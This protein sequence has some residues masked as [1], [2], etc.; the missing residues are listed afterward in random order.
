MHMYVIGMDGGGTKTEGVLVG[1][2][3]H[4]LARHTTGPSNPN[5]CGPETSVRVIAGLAQELAES[6]GVPLTACFLFA[7]IAGSLNH[8]EDMAARLEGLCG[9]RVAVDS[10][11]VNLLSAELADRDGACVI[12]GTGSACFLRMGGELTRIGGWGYLLDSAGSGYDIGRQALEAALRAYDGRGPETVLTAHLAERLGAPV[13]NTLSRLYGEG[14]PLIAS[15]APVVFEAAA[16]GDAIAGAILDRNAVA[17]AEMITTAWQW[18]RAGRGMTSSDEPSMP[19]ALD[20]GVFRRSDPLLRTAV[21]GHIPPDVP[22]ELF[23]AT[24]PVI[25]GAVSEGMRRDGWS[26]ADIRVA[27]PTFLH[28][29]ASARPIDPIS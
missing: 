28:D 11:M 7:G 21:L 13:Q 3:G 16:D 1:R 5:D 27:E 20:G 17:L 9:G 8:K 25:W 2:E 6:A 26:E 29:L 18:Y 10:D 4:V 24:H 14:R 12:S 23:L 22:V 19:V 15:L